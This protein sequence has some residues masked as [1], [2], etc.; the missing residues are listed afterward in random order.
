MAESTINVRFKF[1]QITYSPD[2]KSNLPSILDKQI[3]TQLEQRMSFT[4]NGVERI[5]LDSSIDSNGYKAWLFSSKRMR[6]LPTKLCADGRRESLD[7]AEGEGLGEDMA[8]ACDPEGRIAAIQSNKHAMSEKVLAKMINHFFPDAHIKFL[9]LLRVDALMRLQRAKR[10]KKLHIKVG[11]VKSFDHLKEYGLGASEAISLQKIQQSP[12]VDITWSIGREQ[13]AGLS[14]WIRDVL[15]SA[16]K[17]NKAEPDNNDLK[18]LDAVLQFEEDGAQVTDA[19]DFLTER[20][21]Y[22]AKIPLNEQ[23]EMDE[24]SLLEA[25]CNALKDKRSEIEIYMKKI[26]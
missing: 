21:F 13:K 19:I 17:Y 23:R 9:P 26:K 10:L 20:L 16:I 3:S 2:F 24:K 11:G 22:P 12:I 14:G 25:A 8:I 7:L 6:G 5:L 18:A 4:I 1:Y 15:D